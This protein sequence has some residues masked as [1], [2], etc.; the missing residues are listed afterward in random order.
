MV[1]SFSIVE[2]WVD[3]T[4]VLAVS[5]DLDMVTAPE[6][7]EAIR[8][9][10]RKESTAV[11]VNLTGVTFLSL[12]GINLLIDTQRETPPHRRFRVVAD[13]PATRRPLKLL[14]IDT[15][16]TLHRTMDEALVDDG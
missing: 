5:G 3:D 14:Q 1:D 16:I 8:S 4:V 13:G 2:T 9:A 11:I 6:L 12:A 7:V 10:G 15:V